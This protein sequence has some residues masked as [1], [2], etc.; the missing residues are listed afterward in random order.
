MT[1]FLLG[2]ASHRLPVVIDG[3]TVG[4]A[5]LVARAMAADSLDTMIFSFRNPGAAHTFLL[6]LLAVEPVFDMQISDA[7]GLGSALAIQALE[8]ALVL[9][10]EIRDL[11]V[12]G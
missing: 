2:A 1:G 4:V 10:R 7:G 6:Q 12:A 9:N 11:G 5:A 3:F 8:S